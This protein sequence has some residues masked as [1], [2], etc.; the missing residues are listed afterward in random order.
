MENCGSGIQ[1]DEK[2]IDIHLSLLKSLN[3]KA[4]LCYTD[5]SKQENGLV[6]S[7]FVYYILQ[8]YKLCHLST[9]SCHLGNRNEVY[10]SELHA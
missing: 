6:G 3:N 9:H 7:G 8:N 4:I 5:G 1:K 2:A 10:D